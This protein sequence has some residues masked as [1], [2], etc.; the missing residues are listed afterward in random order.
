[1]LMRKMILMALVVAVVVGCSVKED[2]TV[3]PSRLVLD[4]SGVDTSLVKSLN[5]MAVLDGRVV[6]QDKLFVADFDE[7][8][9]AD[10]PHGKLLVNVWGGGE[11]RAPFN[12]G[13]IIPYGCECPPLYMHSFE[14]DTR[15]EA[16][17][18]VVELCKNHCRLTV[19]MD[20][21]AE[22]PYSLTFK[23]NVDGYM[24]NGLPSSGDF[25]CVAYPSGLGESEALMPR[26]LDSSLLLE[27]DDNSSVSK[28]FAIGEYILA[29]GYDWT[30]KD[31]KDVTICLDFYVTDMKIT[32]Q[33]WDKEYIYDIIL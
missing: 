28:V 15:G 8:Y 30:E 6:L 16:F 24:Q 1:M 26:Q 12:D 29:S 4:L 7:E 25:S 22:I 10:V 17:R 11:D 14:A 33:G 13:L 20:G 27:V 2:R 3:C 23:G 32:I 19:K 18:Q 9:V 5:L 31:L 21:V